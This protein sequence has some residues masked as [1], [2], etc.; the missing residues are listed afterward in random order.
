MHIQVPLFVTPMSLKQEQSLDSGRLSNGMLRMLDNGVT[1]TMHCPLDSSRTDL[2]LETATLYRCFV[3][4]V[5]S[6]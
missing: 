5:E 4:F 3:A 6:Q 1:A 2:S